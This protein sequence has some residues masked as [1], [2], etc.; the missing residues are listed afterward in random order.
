MNTD[1]I[2]I[3]LDNNRIAGTIAIIIVLGGLFGIVQFLI[4]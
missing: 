3:W 2:K 4:K 1:K